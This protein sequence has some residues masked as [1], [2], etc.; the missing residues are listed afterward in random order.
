M[1]EW[2]MISTSNA[3]R[4]NVK[5][6]TAAAFQCGFVNKVVVPER[7][8]DE[9][10]AIAKENFNHALYGLLE[11]QLELERDGMIKAG[12]TTDSKEGFAAF[13]EKRKPHFAAK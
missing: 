1:A 4:V 13:L 10:Y 3:E 8:D 7:L 6:H 9:A 11:R 12:R 2:T 5:T